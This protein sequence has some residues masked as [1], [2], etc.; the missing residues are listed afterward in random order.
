M[1]SNLEQAVYL[2]ASHIIHML[3]VTSIKHQ[4]D[5]LGVKWA[6][7]ML[8]SSKYIIFLIQSCTL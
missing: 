8:N 5:V 6:T 3:H 2:D 4:K 7:Y 1:D